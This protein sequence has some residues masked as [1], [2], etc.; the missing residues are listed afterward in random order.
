MQLSKKYSSK[1]A[2]AIIIA[3]MVGTGVFASL[4]FQ[5]LDIQS[6]FTLLTLWAVGGLTALFG[7]LSYAELGSALPRSGGE[8]YF[9]SK[10]YHPV[11]GFVTG[12][13]STTI[14]FAAPIAMVAILFAGYFTSVFSGMNE[15]LLAALL[16]I[17][18][19][20]IH[21]TNH[22]SSGYI[23]QFLTWLKVG[24]IIVFCLSGF[25]IKQPQSI[26]FYPQ[27]DDIDLIFSSSFAVSLIYVNYAY[28][29]WNSATYISSELENPQKSLPKILLTGT[30]V[31]AVLYVFV[32]AVFLYVAPIEEMKGIKE[33][34]YVAAKYIFGDNGSVIFSLSLSI[35]LISTVSA[36][37]MAGP[38]AFQSIGQ[39]YPAFK[40]LAKTNSN[41]IPVYAIILQSILSLVFIF[42]SSFQSILI[43][44]GFTLGLSNFVTVLGVFVLRYK[45]P[46]LKRPYKTWLYPVTPLLYLL[47]MGWTL[48]HIIIHK[49]GEALMSFAVIAAGIIMYLISLKFNKKIIQD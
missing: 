10:I 38:R 48:I 12:W 42:T 27:R 43:F 9:L 29:G 31:V 11:A 41:E 32:N 15:T 19:T 16:I 25:L 17:V 7:A 36:M 21:V 14:G 13:V 37:T 18:L 2:T 28:M 44:A 3:N 49:P 35:V 34:G 6:G 5:L 1:T 30:L 26:S 8:Y 46:T 20:A 40:I 47:L 39:D 45:Q 4:G 22:K 23:H 24:L 33:I